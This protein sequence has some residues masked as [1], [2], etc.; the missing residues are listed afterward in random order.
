MRRGAWLAL[1]VLFAAAC[2]DEFIPPRTPVKTATVPEATP[3]ERRDAACKSK[4]LPGPPAAKVG[5]GTLDPI[6]TGSVG[7]ISV[8]GATD[9]ARARAAIGIAQGETLTVQKTQ[10]AMKHLYELG[11]YEDVRLEARPSPQGPL[12]RFVLQKRAT[13]GEVVIHGGTL[14]DSPELENAFHAKTGTPYNPVAVVATRVKLI[15]ALRQRGYADASLN[16]VGARAGD[17]NVDLCID[18]HEGSKVA[19]DGI[20]FHGLVKLKE[21]ELKPLIDTDHGRI[22]APGGILDQDKIDEAVSK[23]AEVL[24]A[25]GMAKG[26]IQT[27]TPRS[28]DKVSVVFEVDEGPVI[29][30][31]RYDIKGDLATDAGAYRKLLTLKSKDPFSRAK[32][33]ADMLKIDELHAKQGRQDLKLEPQTQ[34]D[35]KNNTVDIVLLVVDPK[36]IK[37]PPPPPP[38][39]KK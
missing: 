11:D 34:A 6:P 33:R 38:P 36:K 26:I 15:D 39:T 22:N 3:A 30:V 13:L 2:D 9:E 10:D 4:E 16:I 12:L 31:R 32:L 20:A 25:H 17:G 27:K 21:D 18:L 19:I 14:Y 7:H 1:V 8:D 24:D 5:D 23:M 37:A 35:E 28:G 29:V